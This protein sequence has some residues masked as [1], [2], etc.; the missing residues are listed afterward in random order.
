MKIIITEFTNLLHKNVFEGCEIK[1]KNFAIFELGK[2]TSKRKLPTGET[3]KERPIIRMNL[4]KNF[5]FKKDSR[6]TD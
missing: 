5:K 6:E 2:T 1:I 4:S 3:F